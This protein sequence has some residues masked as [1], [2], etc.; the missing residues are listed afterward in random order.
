M[1]RVSLRLVAVR[2]RVADDAG[3][4]RVVRRVN[5]AVRADRAMVRFFEPGVVERRAKPIG[6]GPSGMAGYAS[7]GIHGGNVIRHAATKSLGALPGGQMA[8]VA[9]GVRRSEGVVV[10]NMAG[11][12]G[13]GHVGASQS[14][15][16]RAVIE[17]AIG[18]Q[19]RV[20]A[21]RTL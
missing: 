1:T 19:Q 21:C 5:V 11:S 20:V 8:T 17:L 3:E 12:A 15:T 7:R 6:C 16:R 4:D 14:P 13:R 2:S 9:V 18:P 10:A